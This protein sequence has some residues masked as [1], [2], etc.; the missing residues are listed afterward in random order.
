MKRDMLTMSSL[1]KRIHSFLRSME[2]EA[3]DIGPHSHNEQS[4]LYVYN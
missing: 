3:T 2:N 1:W 4:C